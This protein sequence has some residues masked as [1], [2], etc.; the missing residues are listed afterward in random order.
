MRR[1]LNLLE[2]MECVDLEMAVQVP[3]GHRADVSLDYSK[4]LV[5][6]RL[7]T[8]NG[9]RAWAKICEMKW[10]YCLSGDM[11]NNEW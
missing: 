7:E 6:G 10:R 4:M 3:R 8:R 11:R 9:K 2:H 5:R 1:R